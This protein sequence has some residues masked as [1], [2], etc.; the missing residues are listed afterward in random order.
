MHR[1]GPLSTHG[2]ETFN[3][4]YGDVLCYTAHI[5]VLMVV[6]EKSGWWGCEA[7]AIITES[8][9]ISYFS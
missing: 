8:W 6:E 9:S 1:G 7:L 2:W 4:S 5:G 3:S